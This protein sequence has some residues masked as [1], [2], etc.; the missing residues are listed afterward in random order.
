[1]PVN[2]NAPGT[3]VSQT[4]SAQETSAP[5]SEVQQEVSAQN[6]G[7]AGGTNSDTF[8]PTPSNIAVQVQAMEGDMSPEAQAFLN[9]L[10]Q[11][12]QSMMGTFGPELGALMEQSGGTA[13][14]SG[15]QSRW[16]EFVAQVGHEKGALVDINSL[17][18]AV[19]RDA[20]MENTKDL[21]FYAQKVRYFNE[22]KKLIRNHLTD[23]RDFQVKFTAMYNALPKDGDGKLT[24]E[25]QVELAQWLS[26]NSTDPL[27]QG[28]YN[29]ATDRTAA[30]C[31]A[32]VE[33]RLSTKFGID[34]MPQQ[35]RDKLEA[36]FDPGDDPEAVFNAIKE[37]AGFLAYCG[38]CGMDSNG[39]YG[40][41]GVNDMTH[42]DG[43]G[44]N[45]T[46]YDAEHAWQDYEYYKDDEVNGVANANLASS[47]IALLNDAF[48]TA[49]Y[50]VDLGLSGSSS[51]EQVVAAALDAANDAWKNEIILGK[52]QNSQSIYADIQ[53]NGYGSQTAI[54]VFGS[55]ENAQAAMIAAV[56][57]SSEDEM[58]MRNELGMWG[59][60]PPA[61]CN[62]PDALDNEIQKWEEKLN[63][64]G[65]DA[66][67]ANVDLQNM[68]QKQQQTLQMM[69]NISKMLHDTAMATIRK[70]GG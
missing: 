41:A 42:I 22:M 31:M 10:S 62:S 63:S 49:N 40:A 33:D 2:P 53:A 1:M 68:L 18:Q 32:V 60:I 57:C 59:G 34:P 25:A 69:S 56:N 52:D 19:L 28:V 9:S 16:S 7:A 50:Q 23:M 8:D 3:G 6:S 15:L 11:S 39:V 38:D 55:A 46:S 29:L 51:Y 64:V 21:H 70:I 24:P 37:L 67:L 13:L 48:S 44:A 20:Y 36:A 17:V 43:Y 45:G 54:E 12:S 35:L 30:E 66:Q 4:G 58:H 47:D 61:G 26:A 27:M 5:P 14:T 65:D